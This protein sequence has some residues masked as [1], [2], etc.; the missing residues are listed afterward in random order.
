MKDFYSPTP[1]LFVSIVKNMEVENTCIDGV[2]II[3]SKIFEDS[4]GYFFESYNK[5]VFLEAGLDYD[6]VQDNQSLSSYGVIRGLHFQKGEYAQA[7]LVR[8][9]FGSVLDVVV[10]IRPGSP[11]FGK[12]VAVELTE[13]N[14]YQLMIPRG[15]AHGFAVLSEK[16]VFSY[17]CDNYYNKESEGG[18]VYNDP[19]LGIDWMIPSEKVQVSEKDK[20]NLSFK[21]YC[22]CI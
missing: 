6:F 10:D 9:L 20:E 13:K 22:K 5:R 16:A 21:D 19:D 2:K 12:H 11:T 4:R 3:K 18:L 8:A 15:L 1:S 14:H 17:K 7:K